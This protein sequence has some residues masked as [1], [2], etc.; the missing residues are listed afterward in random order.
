V[1]WDRLPSGDGV[2]AHEWGHNFSRSHAP[3]GTSGDA[4]YP[5]AGGVIGHYGW[6][7]STNALVA[8]TATDIMSYCSNT[9]VSDYNWTAVMNYR[10]SAGSFVA[11][12]NVKGEGL[13][14]WGRVVDGEIQLEPAFRV[15]APMTPASRQATH[16]VD[17]L[18]ENGGALLQLPIETNA[19][20]HVLPGHEERQFAV[21]VPWSASLEQRLSQ[22]RVSDV[23]V[24]MRA[25]SRRS[26]AALPQAFGKGADPRA[27][28]QADP[29]AALERTPRQ[30]KVAW[31]NSSYP[32]AMV[33]DANTGEV[34]G[35]VRQSGA[36]VAT[37]GRSVEVVFSDGVRSTVK[38]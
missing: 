35:F 23:R 16:R 6:N 28:Q 38:R 5:Y 32:M 33:R 36:T 26:T 15:T 10:Q 29:S 24:P 21:V 3:C 22:L 9:W 4:N 37:G 30:V 13:L 12:A 11:S 1:G 20:D 34:M 31:R 18:D 25:A 8:P 7:P 19:V 27:A 2:A 14:V 17:L